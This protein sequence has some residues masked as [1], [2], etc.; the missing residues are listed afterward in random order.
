[1]SKS[2]LGAPG[3]KPGEEEEGEKEEAAQRREHCSP[4]KGCSRGGRQCRSQ[5]VIAS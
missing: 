5:I 1:M 4:G 3:S 2:W